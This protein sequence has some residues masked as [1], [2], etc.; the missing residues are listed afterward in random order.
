[1]IPPVHWPTAAVIIAGGIAV[2]AFG[3]IPPGAI[4]TASGLS[5]AAFIETRHAL[6]WRR[7]I[8]KGLTA[9]C[10]ASA[11]AGLQLA[12]ATQAEWLAPAAF[13][14]PAPIIVTAGSL[15]EICK[16]RGERRR[17][18]KAARKLK[19]RNAAIRRPKEKTRPGIISASPANK[20]TTKRTAQPRWKLPRLVE[21]DGR[22]IPP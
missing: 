4:M 19:T 17:D 2:Q 3:L 10:S 13:A 20:E 5:I 16:P 15:K 6:K 8:A 21:R 1:M 12:T 22:D 14:L 18:A 11:A 9:I 7:G